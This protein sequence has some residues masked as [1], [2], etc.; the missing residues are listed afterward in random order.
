MISSLQPKF[1]H[2]CIRV[3]DVEKSIKFY[4]DALNL[5]VS[6]DRDFPEGKFRLVYMRSEINDFEIELTYNYD[7]EEPYTVGD[8]YSHVAVT[9]PDLKALHVYHQEQGYTVSD[10]K[11]LT[12]SSSGYYFLT[13]PD[14]YRVEVIQESM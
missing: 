5:Q 1:V 3:L 6:R 12:S 13:D 8:G 10:L 4:Q 7:Q 11:A 14:G 2:L 9:V